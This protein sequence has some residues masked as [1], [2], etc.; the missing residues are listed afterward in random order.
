MQSD[1]LSTKKD[2][3]DIKRGV[4]T[5]R[6]SSNN[7]HEL[8]KIIWKSEYTKREEMNKLKEEQRE[9]QRQKGDN[10]L[11]EGL[12]ERDMQIQANKKKRIDETD[13]QRIVDDDKLTERE[14]YEMVMLKAKQMEGKA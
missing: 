8:K 10:Y 7:I 2:L 1:T 4:L 3:P 11:K 13:W 12:Q 14:R 6:N 5:S 9:K